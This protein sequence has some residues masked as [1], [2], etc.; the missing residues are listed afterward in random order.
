M[1]DKPNPVDEEVKLMNNL[2]D[3]ALAAVKRDDGAAALKAINEALESA[4]RLPKK[5]NKHG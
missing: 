5:E 4:L 3:V 1:S 2:L